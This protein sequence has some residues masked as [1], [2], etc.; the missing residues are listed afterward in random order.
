[1]RGDQRRAAI[2]WRAQLRHDGAARF[3]D[4]VEIW[5]KRLAADQRSALGGPAQ[6]QRLGIAG[7]DLD[8]EIIVHRQKEA[9]RARPHFHRRIDAPRQPKQRRRFERNAGPVP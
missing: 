1:M 8:Q 3:S 9:V 5:R 2:S 6:M 4:R 7:D